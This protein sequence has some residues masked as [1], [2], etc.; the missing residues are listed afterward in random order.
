[1]HLV[2][3]LQ[4]KPSHDKASTAKFHVKLTFIKT[5]LKKKIPI[6]KLM[7]TITFYYTSSY[8]QHIFITRT[9]LV[10]DMSQL[11]GLKKTPIAL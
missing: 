10:I 9:V 6:Q 2:A 8:R 11:R 7:Q 4:S 3:R 1:M 5:N